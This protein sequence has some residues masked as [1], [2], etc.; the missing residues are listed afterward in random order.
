[1]ELQDQLKYLR[2]FSKRWEICIE[3]DEEG[4]ED[5]IKEYEKFIADEKLPEMSADELVIHLEQSKT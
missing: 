4:M 5:L 3:N 2:D 1:M